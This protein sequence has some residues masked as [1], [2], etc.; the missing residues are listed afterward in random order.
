MYNIYMHFYKLDI[1]LQIGTM[2]CSA[3]ESDLCTVSPNTLSSSTNHHWGITVDLKNGDCALCSLNLGAPRLLKDGGL[4]VFMCAH[5][6]HNV[7]LR[8]AHSLL[9]C[10]LCSR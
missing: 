3:L 1:C 2:F 10:P 4:R 9:F 5:A 8:V 6:F 7:C